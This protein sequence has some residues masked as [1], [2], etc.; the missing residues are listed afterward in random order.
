MYDKQH[1]DL[2]GNY[3]FFFFF[4]QVQY[5]LFVLVCGFNLLQISFTACFNKRCN[6]TPSVT[7]LMFL[8]VEEIME[9]WTG[10]LICNYFERWIVSVTFSNFYH[11]YIPAQ[12]YVFC[13][14]NIFEF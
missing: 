11:S 5:F 1:F 6:Y 8:S 3:F 4:I 2:V 7:F 13:K 9:L 14:L 10:N 12:F